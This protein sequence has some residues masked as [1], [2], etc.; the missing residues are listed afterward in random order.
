MCYVCA[1]VGVDDVIVFMLY[2]IRV[3]QFLAFLALL[4]AI[5][6]F[7]FFFSVFAI[8]EFANCVLIFSSLPATPIKLN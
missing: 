1:S 6:C 8:C 7:A 5:V 2:V 4:I 3:Y